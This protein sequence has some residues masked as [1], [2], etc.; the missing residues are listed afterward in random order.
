MIWKCGKEKS[1]KNVQLEE[2]WLFQVEKVTGLLPVFAFIKH[3]CSSTNPDQKP[4]K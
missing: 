2:M 1:L 4:T 3:V